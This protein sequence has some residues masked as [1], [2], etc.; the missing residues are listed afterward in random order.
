MIS[1]KFL[2]TIGDVKFLLNKNLLPR[3]WL[4]NS[5]FLPLPLLRHQITNGSPEIAAHTS[6]TFPSI[7]VRE[8]ERI[9]RVWRSTLAVN[10]AWACRVKIKLVRRSNS[11]R[12]PVA[13]AVHGDVVGRDAVGDRVGDGWVVGGDEVAPGLLESGCEVGAV[14]LAWVV[15]VSGRLYVSKKSTLIDWLSVTYPA[16]SAPW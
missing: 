11:V 4:K 14:E 1:C 13:G 10:W 5:C 12:R 15:E 16:T 8:S 6:A 3:P 7:R 2:R 9:R